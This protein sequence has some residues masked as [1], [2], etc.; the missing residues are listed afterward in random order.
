M[1]SHPDTLAFRR[2]YGTALT[3]HK[4]PTHMHEPLCAYLMYGTQPG[5]FLTAVLNNQLVEVFCFADEDNQQKLWGYVGFLTN[6]APPSSWGSPEVVALW[7]RIGGLFGRVA[8]LEALEV[9]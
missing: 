3:H 2:S 5:R 8:D 7:V 1:R 9:Y 4:I 6:A